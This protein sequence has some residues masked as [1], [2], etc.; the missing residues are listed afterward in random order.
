MA[1]AMGLAEAYMG[2]SLRPKGILI[3]GNSDGLLNPSGPSEQKA[4]VDEVGASS[5]VDLEKAVHTLTNQVNE[6]EYAMKS[7]PGMVKDERNAGK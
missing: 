7:R 5:P 4:L 6:L 3:W 1:M 2:R